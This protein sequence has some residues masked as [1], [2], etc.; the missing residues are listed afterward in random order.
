MQFIQNT[1]S[2]RGKLT[3]VVHTNGDAGGDTAIEQTSEMSNVVADPAACTIR[4]HYKKTGQG[5]VLE[6][7]YTISLHDVHDIA[8]VAFEKYALEEHEKEIPYIGDKPGWY[9]KF[10]PPIF[11][12]LARGPG[13]E[14]RGFDYADEKM[15]QS[16]ADALSHA[17][18]L[19]GGG[20]GS[21]TEKR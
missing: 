18:E 4:Y 17:A 14:E 19:C 9:A 20:R 16:I 3:F 11:L 21:L 2:E 7:D 13:D 10:D 6:D 1:L 8:V 12:V 15:A 5:N